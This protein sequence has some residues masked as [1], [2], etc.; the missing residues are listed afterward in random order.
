MPE[1]IGRRITAG[2]ALESETRGEFDETP[3]VYWLRLLSQNHKDK[4]DYVDSKASIGSIVEFTES[5]PNKE[6]AEGGFEAELDY[7]SIGLLLFA[8]FGTVD[9][10]QEGSTGA[11]T[12]E[13]QLDEVAE[14]PSLSY[15][16][17]EPVADK[18][19]PLFSIDTLDF[20]FNLTDR[21]SINVGARSLISSAEASTPTFEDLKLFRPKDVHFYYADDIAG[22][23][24]GGTEVKLKSLE[25][26]FASNLEDDDVLG[27][28]A[29][30]NFLHKVFGVESTVEFLHLD[31]TIKGFFRAGTHKAVRVAIEN[32]S[33]AVYAGVAATGNFTINDYSALTGDTFTVGVV[34]LTEGVDFDA[35]TSNNQ[36]ATNL[37]EAINAL[38]LVNAV[39]VGAQVNITAASVGTAGNLA[40]AVSD[41]VNSARSGAN[42]TGGADAIYASIIFDFAKVYFM[43]DEDNAQDELKKQTI[44]MKFAVSTEEEEVP[45]ARV[46]V[47]NNVEAYDTFA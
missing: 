42:M 13:Y 45:F 43:W 11:Y 5:E 19:F 9:E 34:T 31:E 23:E 22:L 8:L 26:S 7:E 28:G 14:R 21:P 46:V 36:T 18:G 41:A 27:M 38:P 25:L 32:A 1:Y 47:T 30:Q 17:D 37:A 44:E 3:V 2:V 35:E 29:P 15:F 16:V 6:F 39:A 4:V 40:L 12:H 20:S 24:S 33:Q 10:Q